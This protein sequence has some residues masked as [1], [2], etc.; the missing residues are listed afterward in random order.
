MR[1]CRQYTHTFHQCN[2]DD[3]VQCECLQVQ[4]AMKLKALPDLV[5]ILALIQQALQLALEGQA[6]ESAGKTPSMAL[7]AASGESG[8]SG[9]GV[10]V[11]QAC[12]W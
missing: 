8:C 3:T 11:N 12:H 9:R 5:Q 2:M 4:L 7:L 6:S 1:A 10:V